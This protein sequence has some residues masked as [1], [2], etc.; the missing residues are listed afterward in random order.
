[1]SP[2]IVSGLVVA[3]IT[4]SSESSIG[5]LMCQSR[6]SFSCLTTSRSETAVLSDGSQLTNLYPR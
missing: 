4:K 5:Y 3:T 6:P 2:N 1:M